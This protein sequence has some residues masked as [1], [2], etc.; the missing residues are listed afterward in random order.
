MNAY[1]TSEGE[2]RQFTDSLNVKVLDMNDANISFKSISL[3]N[4]KG[5]VAD[6]IVIKNF[7]SPIEVQTII[8]AL[9]Q[10]PEN[11]PPFKASTTYPFSFFQLDREDPN[12]ASILNT[13]YNQSKAFRLS[14]YNRFGVDMEQKFT[15]ILTGLNQ[16]NPAQIL[17]IDDDGSC[18]PFTFRIV[19]PEKNHIKLHAD[20]MFQQF[21]PE[22][23]RNLS[24]KAEVHN[25]LSFFTVLQKPEIGGELSICNVA[26]DV[27]KDFNIEKQSIILENGTHLHTNNPNELFVEQ[28]DLNEG[29][30]IVFPGGQLYHRIEEVYGN[31][32]RI[33][34][35]GFI[36]YSKENKD[37]YYWS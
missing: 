20:N 29:D 18:I 11:K 5:L 23:Y 7:L 24:D 34:M 22:F 10:T 4:L 1:N 21:A 27:A 8:D 37:V 32:A 31:K 33:T 12:F 6:A 35:G 28:F 30:L 16:D 14:F 19:A 2:I 3:Q 15:A 9:F 26:W 36:G 13:Y 17:E 25:Q